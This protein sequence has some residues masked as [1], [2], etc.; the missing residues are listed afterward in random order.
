MKHRVVI[1]I[2]Y[3]GKRAEP[4]AIVD[5]IPATSV[6]WL[7]EQGIIETVTTPEPDTKLLGKSRE[8]KSP[9]KGD[10]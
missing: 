8:P 10:E 6:T 2:D 3:A 9:T 4:G 1:G 7:L 5:D